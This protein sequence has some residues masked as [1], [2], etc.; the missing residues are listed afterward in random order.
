M[1]SL[2]CNN[3]APTVVRSTSFM[4]MSS[5]MADFLTKQ[6]RNATGP[7]SLTLERK[8]WRRVGTFSRL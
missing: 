3:N 4:L 7:G 2:D 1:T 6:P 5:G 8:I